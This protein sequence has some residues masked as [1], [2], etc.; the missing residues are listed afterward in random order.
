[1]S[2]EMVNIQNAIRDVTLIDADTAEAAAT[3]T[4]EIGD[5]VKVYNFPLVAKA[6]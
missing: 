2:K 6:D 1:M 5:E 4:L 3:S